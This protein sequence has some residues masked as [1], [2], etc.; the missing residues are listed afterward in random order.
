MFSRFSEEAQKVLLNAKKEMQELKHPY[1]GTEHLLL[2]LISI[3]KD[4]GKKMAEYGVTYQKFK[5]KL[6]EVVGVGTEDNS[7]FL[8]TPLLKRVLETA[9][10]ISKE[11]GNGE[12]GCDQLLFSILEEGE[13]IAVRI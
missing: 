5:T 1:V 11:S 2:S 3:Q 8:Y 4:I 7:W 6:V 9:I 10:L 13:G 12:V